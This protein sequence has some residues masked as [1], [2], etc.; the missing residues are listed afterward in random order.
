MASH[1]TKR[2]FAAMGFGYPIEHAPKNGDL[3]FLMDARLDARSEELGRWASEVNEWVKPNGTPLRFFPTH[4]R[5]WSPLPQTQKRLPT[6]LIL[7]SVA[8]IVCIGG[9][10]FWI[11]SEDSSSGNSAANLERKFSQER[12]RASV[13]IAGLTAARERE[14]VGLTKQRELKQALDESEKRALALERENA[15]QK[16]TADA[17]QTELKQALDESEKRAGASGQL[18]RSNRSQSDRSQPPMS[19]VEEAKL[20]AH[21][22]SLIK[23]F[24]FAGARLLL[25]HA[26]EKGSAR[27]A[28]MMAETYDW[29][30]LRSLQAY[31]VRG[32][33]EKAW[34]FYQMAARAGIEKARERAEALQQDAN[35][36]TRVGRED[37]SR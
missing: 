23:Q 2:G 30:V 14:N 13:A 31:G 3:I 32:D 22:E 26:S 19:S 5:P 34:E 12:D 33:A 4:W 15:A 16:Q 7:A 25:A 11:E 17:K 27:A 37:R 21:A 10:V 18:T 28:F 1:L 9:I 20:I 29:Q 36:G 8:A 35:F 6:R 24:D